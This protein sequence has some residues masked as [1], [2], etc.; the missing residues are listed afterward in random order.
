MRP[1]STI[2]C[3]AGTSAATIQ[4]IFS[5]IQA[6]FKIDSVTL[7]L[8]QGASVND[9]IPPIFGIRYPAT[10]INVVYPAPLPP[11]Q[12]CGISNTIW[13]PCT[14]IPNNAGTVGTVTCPAGTSL[15]QIQTV[16]NNIPPNTNLGNVIP[17]IPV[18]TTALPP[19]LLGKNAASTIQLIGTAAGALSQLTVSRFL[20][21][22]LG[23]FNCFTDFEL[24]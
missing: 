23:F 21:Y 10:I 6:G 2:V 13:S 8:P 5:N 14:C 11:A 1:M 22:C 19:N 7:S 15:A 24:V 12:S 18:E 9:Y 3:P 17:N 4:S 20:F 16:F